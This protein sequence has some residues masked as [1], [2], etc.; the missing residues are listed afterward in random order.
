MTDEEKN[1]DA[2]AFDYEQHE[3]GRRRWLRAAVVVRRVRAELKLT[4]EQF[5]DL[6]GIARRTVI[7]AEKRGL[8]IP[9]WSNA[10]LRERWDAAIKAAKGRAAS[11]ST[12]APKKAKA[13]RRRAEVQLAL[14]IIG[15]AARRSRRKVSRRR[16][17][18]R[19]K[20]RRKVKRDSGIKLSRRKKKAP[21]RRARARGRRR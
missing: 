9:Y 3:Q 1:A 16:P 21:R 2:G 13:K 14:P 18:S 11:R 12:P 15:R 20:P 5:A 4:Q 17:T 7:R 10:P 6:L 19:T 8:A